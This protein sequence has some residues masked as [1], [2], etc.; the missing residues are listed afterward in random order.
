M[1]NNTNI[2]KNEVDQNSKI[3]KN[4]LILVCGKPG[5]GKTSLISML[6]N[7]DHELKLDPNK[8]ND[9]NPIFFE[10]TVNITDDDFVQTFQFLENFSI[11][12]P[13]HPQVLLLVLGAPDRAIENERLLVNGMRLGCDKAAIILAL[14]RIDLISPVREWNPKTFDPGSFEDEKATNL[15]KW[16]EYVRN[17]LS[18]ETI[19]TVYCCSMPKDELT[20][21]I[22]DLHK[23]LI[24]NYND[25]G[26]LKFITPEINEQPIDDDVKIKIARKTVTVSSV[27]AA[28]TGVLPTGMV[29]FP[30]VLA[31]QTV[32]IYRIGRIFQVDWKTISQFVMPLFGASGALGIQK[33]FISFVPYA[34]LIT[35]AAASSITKAVGEAYIFC[36]CQGT[37]RSDANTFADKIKENLDNTKY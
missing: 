10:H 28:S 34:G 35:A 33:L 29:T 12:Y 8:N 23:S 18:I 13:D 3:N 19:N 6:E 15:I 17:I 4:P 25:A 7:T 24:Q 26:E 27:L 1:N 37:K 11:G 30:T 20:Y 21:G 16:S 14:N 31:I 5:V 9:L 22:D 32:M 2:E 36:L